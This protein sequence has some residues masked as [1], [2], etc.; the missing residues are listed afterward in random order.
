MTG[1]AP[2]GRMLAAQTRAELTMTLR[3]GEQ[4][5][6]TL[7]IPVGLLVTL[8]LVPFVTLPGHDRVGFFLPGV[9]ALAVMS[10]AFTGQAIAVGFERQYGVLKRLGA[11]PLPRAVLLGAKTLAVLAVEL[12]QVGLLGLTGFALGWHPHGS[13][14]AVAALLG[15]GVA[16]FSGL[17]L[18]LGGTVR[19]LTALA[20]ANLL[21]FVLLVLGGVLFPLSRLGGAEP[22]LSLLPTAALSHGLRAVLLDGAALPGRDAA[23]LAGWAVVALGAAVRAFRWE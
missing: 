5:L 10:S 13:D 15:L 9:L 20:A 1:R 4:V 14:L 7:V 22:A 12:L 18:L 21:W 23:A 17:G 3:N 8:T 2:L 6:L 19:G 16:A 11:T